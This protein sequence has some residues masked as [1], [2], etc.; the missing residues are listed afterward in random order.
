MERKHQEVLK[1][2][3]EM[4]LPGFWNDK[5]R[6][7]EISGRAA[8][9]KE[10]ISV[11]QELETELSNLAEL[12]LFSKDRETAGELEARYDGLLKIFEKEKK[13]MFLSGKYDKGDAVVS[14]FAGAGGDD[15]ED[16]ARILSEMYQKYA[17]RQNWRITVL[18]HHQNEHNGTK[19]ITFETA[20]KYAYGYLKGE[21][22]V[23]RLVR[24]SPFSAKKLRH[25]SF[26]LVEI[27]PK[28]V[29]PK[30]VELK[31]EDLEISFT[32]AG[33]PGGQ[34][35]NK[36]ETAVYLKH[37]PTGLSSRVDSERSQAQNKERALQIIRAKI[38]Q[39]EKEKLRR[40]TAAFKKEDVEAEWG[41]QIR[42]YVLH[43]Y[44]MVKDHRTGLEEGNVKKVLEGELDNFIGAELEILSI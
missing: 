18:H 22:G 10:E 40:E 2:E 27:L 9:L 41:H 38:Y 25:T 16:W 42:S 1:F 31:D 29:E 8:G 43:P 17:S 14:I 7:K 11:W 35:V 21:A 5:E 3:S 13:K 33:G 26:A 34:N 23:H 19:N 15:A 20:G 39:K 30:E 4:N 44:K 28:F 32:R 6:A 37:I 24:V 12:V 36:R